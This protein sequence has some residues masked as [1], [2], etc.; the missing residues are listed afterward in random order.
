[1]RL[2]REVIILT[3]ISTKNMS[4]KNIMIAL[5]LSEMDKTL[6]GYTKIL[7][8]FLRPEEIHA[9][10]VQK[11]EEIPDEVLIEFPNLREK[12]ED[13]YIQELVE[14]IESF[15]IV[16][17]SMKYKV[18]QGN[19]LKEVLKKSHDEAIDLLVVGKKNASTNSGLVPQKLARKS[20][21]HVLLVPENVNNE[22]K[23]IL[24]AIDFSDFSKLALQSAIDLASQ[25]GAEIICQHIYEVPTGYSKIGKSFEEFAQIMKGHAEKSFDK[26]IADF[27]TED[28]K[29]TSVFTLNNQQKV[30]SKIEECAEQFNVNLIIIGA[31]GRTNVAAIL[32]GSV[33]E[34]LIGS[35]EKTPILIVKKRDKTF[36]FWKAI[37]EL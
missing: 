37:N 12:L 28:L 2:T 15:D 19:P 6:L 11:H 29:I 9:V 36:G 24:V 23:K 5:D 21:S 32:L 4:I 22:L 26:F 35:M 8:L 25:C 33:T 34:Q 17:T 3:E 10:H 14:R 30:A 18:L 13:A 1:M 7:N 20:S 27:E 16:G 31:R